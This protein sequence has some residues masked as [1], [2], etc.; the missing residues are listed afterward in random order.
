LAGL[1]AAIA[2]LAADK[3]RRETGR[4]QSVK[5]ALSDVA[6]AT[7]GNLG[8]IAD[9][10]INGSNRLREGNYLY[11][12]Y[13]CD[14]ATGDGRRVMLVALTSR[15]WRA[16]ISL[17]GT[18]ETVQALER[19][20]NTDLSDEE[21]RYRYRAVVSAILD[22]WFR[23]RPYA[24]VIEKLDEGNVL[25]GTYRTVEELVHD[26]DSLMA[27]SP[28]MHDVDQ[29]GVG[30]FPTPGPVLRM[31]DASTSQP[32]PAP[33]LG[34][35]THA[36]LQEWLALDDSILSDLGSRGIIARRRPVPARAK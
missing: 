27:V 13:G 36:V 21:A 35:D 29:P 2:V 1:Q 17:T 16:L 5:L 4:G 10:V 12:S 19:A 30:V 24:E 23:S 28:I 34:A 31:G 26:S 15:H 3:V 32:K 33:I 9:V 6:V 11:G 7:M 20:L 25:W 22:P 14:F 8:F 18:G